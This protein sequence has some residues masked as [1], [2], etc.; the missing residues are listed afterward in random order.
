MSSSPSDNN[1]V[2]PNILGE[3]GFLATP[4]NVGTEESHVLST[5]TV[6]EVIGLLRESNNLANSLCSLSVVGLGT[7][8]S[9]CS[10]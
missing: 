6:T 4:N 8:F 1:N 9:H 3:E 10:R 5:P 7:G 2:T